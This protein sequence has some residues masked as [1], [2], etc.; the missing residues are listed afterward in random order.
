MVAGAGYASI[1]VGDAFTLPG[2]FELH[3]ISKQNTGQN[4]GPVNKA[5]RQRVLSAMGGS[6]TQVQPSNSARDQYQNQSKD[7]VAEYRK[8]QAERQKAQQPKPNA[9][10]GRSQTIIAAY[11][12]A[13]EDGKIQDSTTQPQGLPDFDVNGNFVPEQPAQPQQPKPEASLG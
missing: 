4:W 10:A 12:K 1:K 5:Y 7:I 9:D 3:L 13:R 6:N 2:V 11:Q 8:Q